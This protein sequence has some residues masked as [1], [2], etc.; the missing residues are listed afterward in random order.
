MLDGANQHTSGPN[1]VAK[2]RMAEITKVAGDAGLRLEGSDAD[3]AGGWDGW[4][5]GVVW[6]VPT[7]K[8]IPEWK[9]IAMRAL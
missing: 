6:L 3:M 2:E 1:P 9:P 5:G 4:E 8:P 7:D